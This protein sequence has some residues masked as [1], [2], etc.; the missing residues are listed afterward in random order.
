M[1]SK[2][3]AQQAASLARDQ[4]SPLISPAARTAPQLLHGL[5]HTSVLELPVIAIGN[6]RYIEAIMIAVICV[7]F[8]VS[9]GF[10]LG[11]RFGP[12]VAGSKPPFSSSE[13]P[14]EAP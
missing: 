8:A 9:F 11:E 12:H 14:I 3:A 7:R 2:G 13:A 5:N 6:W 4:C 1:P 10:V